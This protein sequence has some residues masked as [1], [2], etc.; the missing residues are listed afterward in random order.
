MRCGL[1]APAK[2]TSF[3]A[4]ITWAAAVISGLSPLAIRRSR[5]IP[6]TAPAVISLAMASAVDAC[7]PSTSAIT[8]A[9]CAHLVSVLRDTPYLA[10]SSVYV[11][12][13]ARSAAN[14]AGR[15]IL[16]GLEPLGGIE[17]PHHPNHPTRTTIDGQGLARGAR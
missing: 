4:A 7:M 16:H 10:A 14:D 8:S 1:P 17:S 2:S 3:D 9:D 13:V 5:C 11:L 6:S 15:A 12:P